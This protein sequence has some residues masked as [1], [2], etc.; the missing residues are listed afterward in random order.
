MR[1]LNRAVSFRLRS[2]GLGL[3]QSEGRARQ[4]VGQPPCDGR[5]SER[6]RTA[7]E[8]S[9]SIR[10]AGARGSHDIEPIRKA[11]ELCYPI[12]RHTGREAGAS[13]EPDRYFSE[14]REP[15]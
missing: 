7:Y 6:G 15:A 13:S 14:P 1:P 11:S 9:D 8:P 5:P 2:L 4:P 3:R 12:R 10:A